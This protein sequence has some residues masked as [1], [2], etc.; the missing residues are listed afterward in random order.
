VFDVDCAG[1][2]PVAGAGTVPTNAWAVKRGMPR[3]FV[4][5][6]GGLQLICVWR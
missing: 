1:E 6:V 5:L 3:N 4:Y 2:V